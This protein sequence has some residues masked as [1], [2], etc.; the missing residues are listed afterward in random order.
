MFKKISRK[1]M[2][3]IVAFA[4]MLCLASTAL[5]TSDAEVP[6]G[7]VAYNDFSEQ[8]YDTLE[9]ALES[10]D[11][12]ET[13][14]LVT[15]YTLKKS[16]E[17]KA[18]V[19]LL[20]PTSD[21]WND[22]ETGANNVP[23]NGTTGSA[24]VT[25]TIPADY[26]LKVSGTLLVAGNQQSTQPRSGFLTGYYGAVNLEGSIE[27]EKG[28]TLYARGE[29]AGIGNGTVT[30]VSG[31][32]VY[33]R[34]QIAD[35]RGGTAS[36][37]AYY[38]GVFPFSLFELGGITANV[39]IEN[40]ATLYGQ[41]YIY[42]NSQENDV[43]VYYIGPNGLLQF[44]STTGNVAFTHNGTDTT[45]NINSA[46]KTGNLTFTLSVFGIPYSISS[47]GLECPFGYHTNI[48]VNSS[49]SVDI[50]SKLKFLPG[51]DVTIN[52][53]GTVTIN[54]GMEMNFFGKGTY[55]DTFYL[56][57]AASWDVDDPATLHVNGTL[58]ISGVLSSS[59]ETFSN[60]TG[61]TFTATGTTVNIKEAIQSVGSTAVT[62]ET[63]PFYGC[64]E[65]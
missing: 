1:T 50:N 19:R 53:G 44:T 20:I 21:A 46:V 13:V 15:D 55:K 65:A 61:R 62:Y 38:A 11:S 29:I 7:K 42:A 17:V 10:A 37:S 60:L 51:C 34:F 57:N 39:V 45:I 52:E 16:V 33:Q 59:D 30:A 14:V 3:L 40:G 22:T 12:D 8:Y 64:K 63:V 32:T 23:N 9:E 2:S 6:A 5:A 58:T 4:M 24:Y 48:T 18:G 54:E 41:C 26:T 49:G 28:G 35:W 27:V 36:Q 43:T 25:L 47:S 56:G 31:S